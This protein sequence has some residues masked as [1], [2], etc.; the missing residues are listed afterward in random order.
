MS[1]NRHGRPSKVEIRG[2]GGK[3]ATIRCVDLPGVF[4]ESDLNPLS[5]GWIDAEGKRGFLVVNGH[6]FGH[7][8]GLCQYGA[9]AM[10][11]SALTYER[12]IQFYYPQGELTKAW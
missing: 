1:P 10:A 2:S 4:A 9:E 12:I 8:A 6:G 5:S 3:T 11:A 7:G